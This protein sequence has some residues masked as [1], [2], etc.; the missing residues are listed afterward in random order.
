MIDKLKTL[1]AANDLPTLSDSE[2]EAIADRS[3]GD[4]NYAASE[5]WL[6]KMAK[7]VT[8]IDF[9]ADGATFNR[10]QFMEHAQIM[11][12]MYMDRVAATVKVTKGG[13]PL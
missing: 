13:T 3:G 11:R 10:S 1:V 5:A 8:M 9:S 4:L 7:S 6:L 2:L 12:D